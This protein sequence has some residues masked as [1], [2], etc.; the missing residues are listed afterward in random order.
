VSRQ[1][2]DPAELGLQPCLSEDLRGGDAV[3]N[4]QAM[5]AVFAGHDAGPHRNALVL[6]CGLGLYIAGRSASVAAG[7]R[8]AA[9]ALDSGR[10]RAW[11]GR[12]EQFSAQGAAVAPATGAR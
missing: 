8:T 5:R 9:E 6:Q 12:L 3:A 4:C 2:L 1:I 10:A 7:I 11:L